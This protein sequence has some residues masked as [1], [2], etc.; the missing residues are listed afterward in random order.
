MLAPAT[1]E[2]VAVTPRR[3]LGPLR[4]ADAN[5]LEAFPDARQS[6][7]VSRHPQAGVTEQALAF[8]DRLPALLHRCQVPSLAAVTD[9]PQASTLRIERQ[10]PAD[11]KML[12][13]VV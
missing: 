11:R 7:V 6:D 4:R 10:P 8:L 2:L 12:D 9:H 13:R 3:Q 5:E 1:A